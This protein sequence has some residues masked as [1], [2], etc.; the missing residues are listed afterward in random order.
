MKTTAFLIRVLICFLLSLVPLNDLEQ[1]V[2]LSL[3]HI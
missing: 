1:R 2:Y 3:I